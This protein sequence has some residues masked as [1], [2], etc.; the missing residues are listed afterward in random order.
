MATTTAIVFCPHPGLAAIIPILWNLVG[1]GALWRMLEIKGPSWIELV[2]PVQED[3]CAV[4]DLLTRFS[5]VSG[6]CTNFAK[7]HVILIC[8]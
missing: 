8:C 3:V 6:L 2:N 5:D 4:A 7:S 1:Y